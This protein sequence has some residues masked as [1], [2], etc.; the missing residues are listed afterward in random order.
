MAKVGV[1]VCHCGSNIAGVVDVAAVR[2]YAETLPDVVVSR[3]Y[4][5]MCSDPGQELIRKDI[6]DGLVDRVVVAACTPRTH[7][8]IFRKALES[9]GLNKYFFEMANIRDQDSWVHGDDHA[10]ATRKAK[11]LVASA[12]AKAANLEALEDTYVDVTQ[13]AMVVGGGVAGIFAALDLANMGHKVYLV[14][15]EPSI[16]GVMAQ[17][18]K[19]FPTNDCSA[20]ILTPIMVEV[21]THPNIEMLTYAEVEDVDGYIGNFKVKVRKKQTY[22]DWTKCTGCGACAEACPAKVPDSFNC[23]MNDRGAAYIHFP[24]AVPK[25]AVVD[26]KHCLNCAGHKIGQEPRISK[27]TG[28]PMLAPCEKACAADAINRSLPWNPEGELIEIEVGTV[29]LATGYR[30]ME[31]E[32]FKEYAPDSPNVLTALQMERLISATGPTGG[33]LLRPSDGKKPKVLDFISCVGSRDIRHHTY[34]SRVCCMYM[35]KQARLLMEK[36]PD[37][38]IYMHFIDV[39][40]PGKDFDEYYTH[41]AEMGIHFIKGKPGGIEMLPDDRLR[42]LGYDSAMGENIEVD[43]DLVI[44]ATAI[45]LPEDAQKLAQKFSMT[46]DGSGFFKELHPKL[47]PVDT[48]IEGVFLAGCCQGPKDIPDTVAQ[49]KAAAASAAIP[50]AQKRVKIEPILSEVYPEKCSGCGICVPLCPYNAISLK[51]YADRPRAVIDMTQCKGCGV[52]ASACP[53]GAIILHGYTDDQIYSQIAAL[54]QSA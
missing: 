42:V 23:G 28:E 20:C 40:T 27:K 52:C 21:G 24:Q 5:F 41:A 53:S 49:A 38:E 7:E 17:L 1:Y 13:A 22:V 12:V 45:E 44:L 33:K 19:T 14:E 9:A 51:P 32:H 2:E 4:L 26:M 50:L 15:K 46:M 36:Y 3:E 25:K 39:R 10:G 18:D 47:K 16:G 43:A 11:Q 30:V 31:K 8:P 48:P 34:C 29:V 54:T 6:K 35:I 37:L